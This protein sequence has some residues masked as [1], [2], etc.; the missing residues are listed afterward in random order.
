[1]CGD[2]PCDPK[3]WSQ[4]YKA[5]AT[6]R[7]GPAAVANYQDDTKHYQRSVPRVTDSRIKEEKKED[8][9]SQ[10]L[11]KVMYL[12]DD[13]EVL[14]ERAEEMKE[15]ADQAG[16]KVREKWEQ[17]QD[18]LEL[19]LDLLDRYREEQERLIAEMTE[20]LAAHKLDEM[21][22]KKWWDE[23]GDAADL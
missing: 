20:E 17:F 2:A 6:S 22:H 12:K 13:V 1:M 15:A 14:E 19:K 3:E 18:V 10:L 21:E 5:L 7:F 11:I 4:A 23:W 9:T 8:S 16:E